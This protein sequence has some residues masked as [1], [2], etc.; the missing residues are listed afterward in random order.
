MTLNEVSIRQPAPE[1]TLPA[2]GGRPVSLNGYR[3]HKIILFFYSKD[4]T[5]G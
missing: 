1:F 2:T 4:G 5:S 3:G